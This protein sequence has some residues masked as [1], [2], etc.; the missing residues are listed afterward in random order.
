[1]KP[2]DSDEVHRASASRR[3]RVARSEFPGG[4]VPGGHSLSRR[5]CTVTVVW[6]NDH[7]TV[8]YHFQP[9]PP[10]PIRPSTPATC[11]SPTRAREPASGVLTRRAPPQLLNGS[12]ARTN[13]VAAT[14]IERSRDRP[15]APR[16]CAIETREPA[17]AARRSFAFGRRFVY[18][19]LR[20]RSASG[21]L[22]ALQRMQ[23]CRSR[24]RRSAASKLAIL[25]RSGREL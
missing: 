24:V 1:M 25:P 22:R 8:G 4:L 3:T 16:A 20:Q 21:A 11:S 15:V 6:T 17:Q 2:I 5:S 23:I 12:D 14:S 10:G 13:E 19:H 7:A 18:P 9:H